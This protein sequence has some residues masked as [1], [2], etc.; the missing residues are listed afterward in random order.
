M[1]F[2]YAN[3]IVFLLCITAFGYYSFKTEPHT[4]L[5]YW[6]VLLT[7]LASI[8]SGFAEVVIESKHS[9]DGGE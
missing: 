6:E 7:G 8:A 5:Y 2:Q 9:D 4:D 1:K 3:R